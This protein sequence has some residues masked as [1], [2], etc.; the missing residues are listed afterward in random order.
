MNPSSV[1]PVVRLF[2]PCLAIRCDT[3]VSPNRYTLDGPFYA[4]R[5]PPGLGYGFRA[6]EIWLFCQLSDATG[7]QVFAID[8]SYDLDVE[9][10][11]LR[12]FRVDMGTDKLAVRHYAIP[13]R[14]IPFRRPGMYEFR[15]RSGTSVLARAAVRLE[16]VG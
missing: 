10:R 6:D 15:L 3:T 9:V 7:P 11:E 1:P 5:P 14:G 2:I 4:L 13:V 8:L 12:T 16:D